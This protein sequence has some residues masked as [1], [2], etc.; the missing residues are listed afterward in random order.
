MRDW[1]F[2]KTCL[3]NIDIFLCIIVINP[4]LSPATSQRLWSG[5]Y[6]T[7]SIRACVRLFITFLY[8]FITFI[9]HLCIKVSSPNLQGMF[10]AMK[11]CV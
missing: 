7:S 4:L 9:S 11:T 3:E 5:D 8:W 2:G 10:I 6:K 1:E